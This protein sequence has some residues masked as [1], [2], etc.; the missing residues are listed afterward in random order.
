LLPVVVITGS[1]LVVATGVYVFLG[2]RLLQRPVPAPVRLPAA[3]FALFWLGLGGTTMAEA[4]LNLWDAIAV[5][6]IPLVATLL[7]LE[8][9]LICVALWGLLSYLAFLY[10]GRGYLAF[11]S[12]FYGA[13]YL[14]LNYLISAAAPHAVVVVNGTVSVSY[15][16]SIS[17]PLAY[18]LV[19]VLI[20]P[21]FVG[22]VLYLTLAF[23]S[24]DPTVRFR[25]VVVSGGLIAWFLFAAVGSLVAAAA[26]LAGALVIQF[27]GVLA[28]LAILAAYYPPQFVR[29]RLGVHGTDAV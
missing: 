28:A 20:V 8:I 26:G 27:L 11:W 4:F 25:I 24:P 23:R 2:Y 10:T 21:E 5:P 14:A 18:A 7:H 29:D 22:A 6:S 1:F 9:L 12:I 17:G 3:Q 15:A 13:C 16:N 19:V